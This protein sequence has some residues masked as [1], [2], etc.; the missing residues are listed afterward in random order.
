VTNKPG[1]GLERLQLELQWSRARDNPLPPPPTPGKTPADK[2][3]AKV[4]AQAASPPPEPAYGK[5]YNPF[6]VNALRS[7]LPPEVAQRQLRG[8]PVLHNQPLSQLR[9]VGSLS[10]RD[11]RQGLLAF[12][13]LVY[14]VHIGDHLGQDWGEVTDIARDHLLL[15]EWHAH[16]QGEWQAQTRRIA[17][18][19]TK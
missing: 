9:W 10:R 11:Q 17:A 4:T 15:R 12:N 3:T 14:S 18:G 1:Q 7:G 16:T 19:D 2:A 13:G 6:V 8:W 5:L